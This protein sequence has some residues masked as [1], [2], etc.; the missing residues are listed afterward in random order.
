MVNLAQNDEV[1]WFRV[2]LATEFP[3]ETIQSFTAQHA[4]FVDSCVCVCAAGSACHVN[5]NV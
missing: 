2:G 1:P 5:R 3:R 4:I